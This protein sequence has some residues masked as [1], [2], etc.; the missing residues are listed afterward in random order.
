MNPRKAVAVTQTFKV[1]NEDEE[2]RKNI[3]TI[4]DL[5]INGQEKGFLDEKDVISLKYK[6]LSLVA[7]M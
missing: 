7:G 2:R 1:V 6:V 5:V 3:Y 4:M